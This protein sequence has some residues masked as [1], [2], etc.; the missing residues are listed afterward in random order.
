LIAGVPRAGKS[1]LGDAIE[2]AGL[3][4]TH[5]PLDRYVRPI[6][7]PLTFLEWLR[8]PAC[9]DWPTLA[10][11]LAILESGRHCFTPRPDW[12][13]GWGEWICAGGHIDHGPG[14]RMEP[15]SV[16]YVVPGTHAFACP[17]QDGQAVRIFL[18]TADDVI[19]ERLRG[20]PVEPREVH[21]VLLDRLGSNPAVI[22]AEA[23]KADYTM[24][25]TQTPKAQLARFAEIT[26]EFY[27]R[28]QLDMERDVV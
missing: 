24:S 4:Y 26:A 23:G 3:G 19:A 13:G 18:E 16:G 15:A 21:H 28:R 20:A 6:P 1:S 7:S 9:I 14:R 22:E 12:K 2:A 5:V 25:G 10:E 8:T 11:H 27:G 17:S